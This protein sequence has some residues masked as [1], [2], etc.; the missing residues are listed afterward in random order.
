MPFCRFH[1]GAASLIKR[2]RINP[3]ILLFLLA[4]GVAHAQFV[5]FN[6]HA[7]GAGTAANTTTWNIFGNSPGSSGALKDIISGAVLP[8]TVTITRNGTV[9]AS[10]TGANPNSGTPL[11]NTFNGYVDFQGSGDADAVAQVTGSSTVTYTFSGLNPNK[12]YSFKGS[13]VRGG[14]GGNHPQSWSLFE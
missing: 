7:P 10:P 9:N 1:S 8:V 11:Y 6:D 13:A 4:A 12:S 5:A 14:V 3:P 2:R